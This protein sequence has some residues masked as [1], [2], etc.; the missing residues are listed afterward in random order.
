MISMPSHYQGYR[1]LALCAA[2][3][4]V[5]SMCIIQVVEAGHLHTHSDVPAECML[6][7]VSADTA[8]VSADFTL[9]YM[10]VP[11]GPARQRVLP[12]SVRTV[13]L[14]PSRGPPSHF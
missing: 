11:A 3:L 12:S 2:L 10:S 5:L 6:S 14:P 7:V 13:A 8:I 1:K 4:A 9:D